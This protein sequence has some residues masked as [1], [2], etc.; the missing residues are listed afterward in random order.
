MS[1]WLGEGVPV[2]EVVCSGQEGRWD[3]NEAWGR[4]EGKD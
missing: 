4:G 2:G 3:E 1:A